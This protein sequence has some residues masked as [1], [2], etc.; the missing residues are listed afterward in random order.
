[1]TGLFGV[2]GGFLIIPF[3]IIPALVLLPGVEMAVAV[4]TSLLIVAVNS[5][6]GLIA[7]LGHLSLDWALVA[8]FTVTTVGGSLVA[9]RC[10]ADTSTGPVCNGGS[11]S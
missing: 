9:G 2:G 4:G 5:G 11:P 3:L 1:M 10:T 6:S 7:T 8:A